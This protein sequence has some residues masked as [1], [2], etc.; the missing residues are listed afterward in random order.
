MK[1]EG[2]EM[3]DGN[4]KTTSTLNPCQ[5]LNKQNQT[6]RFF[7]RSLLKHKQTYFDFRKISLIGKSI[8][9]PSLFLSLVLLFSFAFL[10]RIFREKFQINFHFRLQRNWVEYEEGRI[11]YWLIFC[12]CFFVL[13]IFL[14]FTSF[15]ACQSFCA[16]DLLISSL[17][18][19]LH[20]SLT[21]THSLYKLIQYSL[22]FL[23]PGKNCL[24]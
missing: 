19:F 17:K 23:N 4:D 9:A 14:L 7:V 24:Q 15:S 16:Y 13:N 10:L 20:F 12:C 18:L 21:F 22:M 3:R 6:H 2:W 11:V 1:G 5:R 8:T